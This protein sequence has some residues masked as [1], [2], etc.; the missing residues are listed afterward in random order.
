VHQGRAFVV[1]VGDG[2]R[3][4]PCFTA[5]TAEAVRVETKTLVHTRRGARNRPTAFARD[6]LDSDAFLFLSQITCSRDAAD[7]NSTPSAHSATERP[8]VSA[9]T[10]RLLTMILQLFLDLEIN[11]PAA[12]RICR[13]GSAGF[14]VK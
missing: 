2:I 12:V 8:L 1:G 11:L 7:T 3:E 5:G 14:G 9:V 10:L 6:S 13:N 4:P